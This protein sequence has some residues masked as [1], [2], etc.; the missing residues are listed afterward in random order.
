MEVVPFALH[1]SWAHEKQPFLDFAKRVWQSL[2][3]EGEKR[4]R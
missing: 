1:F 3:G 4:S 2:S